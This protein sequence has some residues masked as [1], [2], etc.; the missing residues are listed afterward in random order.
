[1]VFGLECHIEEDHF[2]CFVNQ[3]NQIKELSLKK[4]ENF[5]VSL[6]NVY[7]NHMNSKVNKTVLKYT[8][9]YLLL[10]NKDEKDYPIVIY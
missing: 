4:E 3:G 7:T 2:V 6:E 8:K 5:G 10:F 9:N 1:M